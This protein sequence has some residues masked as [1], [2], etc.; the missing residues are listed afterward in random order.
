MFRFMKV[1]NVMLMSHLSS[2]ML[3]AALALGISVFS[4]GFEGGVFNTTQAMPSRLPL[5]IEMFGE[6]NLAT[7]KSSIPLI[8]Y[9]VGVVITSQL[10]ERFGH[11][12]VFLLMNSICIS[13]VAISYTSTTHIG[14]EAALVPMYMAEPNTSNIFANFVSSIITNFT[15]KYPDRSSWRVPFAIIFAFPALALL[16]SVFLPDSPR[17]LRQALEGSAEQGRWSD[18]FK[19]TNKK[20]TITAVV[21]ACSSMLTEM[22]FAANYSTV[23]LAQFNIMDSF[24]A[25]MIKRAVL[26]LGPITVMTCIE[27]LGRRKTFLGMDSL[28]ASSLLMMGVLGAIQPASDGLKRGIVAVSILF[29]YTYIA[30]FG[31]IMQIVPSE[32]SHISLRDKTS[33]LRF[34]LPYLLSTPYAALAAKVAFIYAATSV[35]LLVWAY[36]CYHELTSRSLEE[37]DELSAEGVSAWRSAKWVSTSKMGQLTA[38]ENSKGDAGPMLS[39]KVVNQDA[40]SARHVENGVDKN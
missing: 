18:M 2:N 5:F 11:R 23:F 9:A 28:S 30:S 6:H 31:S 25:T 26:L 32:I 24:T 16:L 34:S 20:R 8:T 17:W 1:R 22:S 21:A 14:M 37:V 40:E 35:C 4:Y 13:G 38:M 33:M 12:I 7:G 10:S 3:L 39:E 15:S 19:G 29:T 27:R 36:F